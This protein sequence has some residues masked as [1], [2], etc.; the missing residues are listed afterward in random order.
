MRVHSRWRSSSAV[1]NDSMRF[2]TITIEK[3]GVFNSRTVSLP[4]TSGLVV[5]YGPNAAGKSTCLAA[6]TDFLFGIP[7][8]SAY[9][10]VFGYDQMGLSASLRLAGG[11]QFTFRR[12]KGRQG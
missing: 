6:V 9:G 10:Q 12:R 5:I 8:N 2:L 7:H 1:G 3:Y 4:E 11:T